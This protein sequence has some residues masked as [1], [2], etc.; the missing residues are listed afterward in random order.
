MPSPRATYLAA[1][2]TILSRITQANGFQTDAGLL[3]SLEPAP[4]LAED[5]TPFITAVWSRQ[6]RPTEVARV[7]THRLTTIDVV[8]RLPTT[9]KDAQETLDLI[10]ADIEAAF[11][12]QQPLFPV[13]YEF[14]Q[15]QSAAPL[16]AA[17]ASGVCGV[18]VTYAGHIPIR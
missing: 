5:D 15:Y 7:R 10:V 13:G 9:Y 2:Q 4:A 11:Q 16:P 1:F 6:A 18:V 12:G 3:F 14:P 17:A 8:A